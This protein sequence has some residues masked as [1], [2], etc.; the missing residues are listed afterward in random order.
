MKELLN[1]TLTDRYGNASE[2]VYVPCFL[3]SDV[4]EGAERVPHPAF[5]VDGRVLSGIWIA[6]YQCSLTDGCAV[7]VGGVDPATE[8]S[9][10]CAVEAARRKGTGWHLM[11]ASEWGAL[12]LLAL[13]TGRLP[14]GN[15]DLGRDVRETDVTAEIA[16]SD[17]E[18][19]ICR[20]KTGTGPLAWSHNGRADG[21]WDLNGNVWEWSGGIRLVYGE[22]QLLR[23]HGANAAYPQDAESPYWCAID[24]ATGA[25]ITPSG[26]G[27]TKG[28]V[29]LDFVDGVWTYTGGD[30]TSYHEKPRF[31]DF[32]DVTATEDVS[33]AARTLLTAIGLF[34]TGDA[35]LYGGVSL[36]ANNG[37]PERMLFRG[38]RWGQGE[39]AGV[40]KNCLDDPRTYAGAAV[41]FR[42]A[43][44][45]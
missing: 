14:Y 30:V 6:K 24:A 44:Y 8:I 33:A 1:K 32:A 4:I 36:Y 5:T 13:G 20:V 25:C 7:S 17:A 26:D 38:G 11:T 40:F 29:K 31:C 41:G 10:D 18:K 15:N 3:L 2:M 28:S 27:R 12:A 39:N 45:E 21:V 34:P 43:Y 42:I 23:E 9:F 37:R 22:L 35:S 16:Y 19:G